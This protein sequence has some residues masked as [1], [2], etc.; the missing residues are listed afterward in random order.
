LVKR[1]AALIFCRRFPGHKSKTQNQKPKTQNLEPG[2]WNLEPGTWN[3]ELAFYQ[4][5][6]A[7]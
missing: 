5:F 3:L 7:G 6:L 4:E 1:K 2:T